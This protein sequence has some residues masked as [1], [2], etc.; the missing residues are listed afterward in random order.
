[1]HSNIQ[2]FHLAGLDLYFHFIHSD[3]DLKRFYEHFGEG[4]FQAAKRI[5]FFHFP[6]SFK[7]GLVH[8]FPF[9]FLSG[10]KPIHIRKKN[11][12][13]TQTNIL[14]YYSNVLSFKV[15][16]PSSI[17]LTL[18]KKFFVFFFM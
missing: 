2:Q 17:T 9:F 6:D 18:K 10:V 5:F 8:F 14:K 15:S 16:L 1:M 13:L 11:L 4:G 12:S 7:E 3:T